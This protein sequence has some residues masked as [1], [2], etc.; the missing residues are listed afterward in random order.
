MGCDARVFVGDWLALAGCLAPASV[1]LLYVDPPFNTGKVQRSPV[2]GDG[3]QRRTGDAYADAWPDTA[4]YVAWV[5]E[6]LEATLPA[7]KQS[8]SVLLHCDWRASHRLRVLLDELLGEDRFVNHLVWSYGLGGSSPRTF[9][10]K[11]DDILFYCVD[12]AQYYFEAPKVAATSMRLAGKMKKATDVLDIASLNNMAHERTGYPT[13]KPLAL[14]DVLVRACCPEGGVVLDP[15]CGSGTTAVAAVRARRSA[16][17]GDRSAAAI[18]LATA[19]VEEAGLRV[20][21]IVARA[22]AAGG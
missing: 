10:R 12:P 15:C 6:R 16:I 19:R 7:L 14:L 3:M 21:S 13:Q 1:D 22:G 9:A 11:H 18:A 20:V 2:R 5:R 4:S 17:A 8:G